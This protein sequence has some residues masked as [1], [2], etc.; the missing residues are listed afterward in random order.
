MSYQPPPPPQQPYGYYGA[1]PPQGYWAPPPQ[2]D[3]KDLRPPRLWYWLSAIPA[4]VGTG[5]AIFLLVDLIGQFDTG[6]ANFRTP[7]STTVEL[8]AGDERGI[9]LQ[10]AGAPGARPASSVSLS[11]SVAAPGGR[12]VELKGASG[13][14]ITSGSDEYVEDSRFVAPADGAY[15]V[16]C[17][18]P[19]G[20]PAAVGPHVA[21]RNFW[22]PLVGMILAF[23]AGITISAIIAV[24]TAV[25]RSHHKQ[26]LR[27]EAVQDASA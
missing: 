1:Y 20:V 25:R 10:T 21:L 23:L 24:V 11:C 19:T 6:I 7:G 8:D 12:P 9:Y 4:V 13:F 3:P 18:S 27:R 16:G 15:D 2:I 22:G 5:I 26:R 17:S 14:T